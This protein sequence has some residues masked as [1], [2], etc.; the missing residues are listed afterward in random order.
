MLEIP[1]AL[2]IPEIVFRVVHYLNA[3]D[4]LACSSVSRSFYSSFSP[5]VWENLHFGQPCDLD[6]DLEP[7]ARNL[8]IG[9]ILQPRQE[10]ADIRS[11]LLSLGI[12]NKAPLIRSLSIH[13]HTTLLPLVLGRECTQLNSITME[14]LSVRDKRHTKEHWNSCKDIF[15]RNQSSL[16]SI[17][18]INWEYSSYMKTQPGQPKWNPIQ[19]CTEAINLRSLSLEKC[20]IRGRFTRIFWTTCERLESLRLDDVRFD[21]SNSPLARRTNNN[22]SV[23]TSKY[24][25]TRLKDLR[26]RSIIS[27]T[28]MQLLNQ[29][30]RHCP[31]L[32]KLYWD[33]FSYDVREVFCDLYTAST[34]P[35]LDWIV[36]LKYIGDIEFAKLL[37]SAKKPFR[38]LDF[39]VADLQPESYKLFRRHF[40]TIRKIHLVRHSGYSN[41]WAIEILTS[42]PLLESLKTDN[43]TAQE[44]SESGPWICKR[45]KVLRIFIDMGFNENANNR[46]LTSE[47]LKLCHLVYSRLAS[48][49]EL[50]KLDMLSTYNLANIGARAQLRTLVPLPVR[51][52]A[53]LGQLEAL[54]KLEEISFWSGKQAIHKKE[55]IWM[56]DYWKQLKSIEGYWQILKGTMAEDHVKFLRSGELREWL[57][58][59]GISVQLCC[60]H[61]YLLGSPEDAPCEDWCESSDSEN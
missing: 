40:S 48:L 27:V 13:S 44:I 8:T 6:D 49:K 32:Q 21:L 43:M 36:I 14:G 26:L 52:R 59:R 29:L 10:S 23:G 38:R 18:L 53:G 12:L 28:S 4:V 3:A 31:N 35:D 22:E 1:H 41:G 60:Y 20:M 11:E 17:S 19:R 47:E 58:D 57:V 16:K 9:I 33:L 45:L 2:E 7:L 24:N 30:I 50:R 25:F 42:C 37:Q 46:K 5:F 51:L 55:L 15:K 39:F 34:W 54:D 56:V 61:H